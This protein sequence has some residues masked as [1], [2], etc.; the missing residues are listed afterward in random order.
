MTGEE[1]TP[2]VSCIV[3]VHNGEKHLGATLA[4]IVAQSWSNLEIVVVDD[5]STDASAEIAAAVD[6]RVRVVPCE[7]RGPAAARNAGVLAARGDYVAFLDADD[8]WLAHKLEVQMAFLMENPATDLCTSLAV[9]FIDGDTDHEEMRR[10]Y[11]SG[12]MTKAWGG[13]SII[14]LVT[15]RSTFDRF[16]LLDESSRTAECSQWFAQAV[17]A[18]ASLQ[19]IPEVLARRRLHDANT[20]GE[21]DR[22]DSSDAMLRL[23]KSRLDRQRRKGAEGS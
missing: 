22:E 16:G 12:R 6:P 13:Y 5:H 7:G 15:R 3:P 1:P 18:G 14:A 9:N 23:I 19:E 20:T 17:A 8:L 21:M 11:G 4:S 10:R 2:L